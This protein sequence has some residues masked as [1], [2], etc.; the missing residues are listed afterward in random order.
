[1][2]PRGR[3]EA[4][5]ALVQD[6]M[7]ANDVPGASVAIVHHGDVVYQPSYGVADRAAERP[8]TDSTIYQLASATKAI[9][10]A[11][12]WTSVP[13][14]D[15]TIDA[16]EGYGIGWTVDAQE[17]HRRVWHSGGGKALVAHYPDDALT[18]ILLTNRAG[19][20]VVSPAFEI[21]ALYL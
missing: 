4:V 18:V 13:F 21:A 17:G 1:V 2:S 7:D 15:T 11:A 20:D 12:M 3:A 8:A 9:A 19:F 14:D 5:D 16:I 6:V 10:R